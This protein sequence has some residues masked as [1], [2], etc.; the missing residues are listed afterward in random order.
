MTLA[1]IT[2]AY[3]AF[4]NGGVR[5]DHRGLMKVLDRNDRP[6]YVAP[7]ASGR[8]VMTPETAYVVS[9]LLR[10]VTTRGLSKRIGETVPFWVGGKTGTTNK[11]TD[12][13]FIGFSSTLAAGVWVGL[14]SHAPM[15]WGESGGRA[16]QPIF[17]DFMSKAGPR[18]DPA[19]EL[20]MPPGVVRVD[21]DPATGYLATEGCAEKI[22]VAFVLGTEPTK[23]CPEDNAVSDLRYSLDVDLRDAPEPVPAP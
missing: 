1:E 13:L 20:A 10:G 18:F 23:P 8:A 22:S 2:R 17:L 4:A 6:L 16:A 14:D 19:V 7:P 9:D 5:T 11:S 15:P 3:S 21:V 12:S